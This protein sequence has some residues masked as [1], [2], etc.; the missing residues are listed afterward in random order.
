VPGRGDF[1]F[2]LG[3]WVA[4]WGEAGARGRNVVAKTFEGR[5]VEE[6]FDGRPGVAFQGMSVS[7]YD[8]H[9]DRWL[10]T[11]VDDEGNYFALE[12][13]MQDGAMVLLCDRHNAEDRNLR[14][15]MRFSDIEQD[16]FRW[17]W[18]RSTDG[19]ETYVLAWQIDYRRE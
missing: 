6:R 5:V 16:S 15:R 1:D 3:S 13:A 7:V 17:T 2:W 19:G 14:Y 11:W 8:E 4:T 12:G 18:E 9:R 10:Q